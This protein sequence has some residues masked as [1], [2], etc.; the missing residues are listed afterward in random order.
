M[1]YNSLY[2]LYVSETSLWYAL[3]F[4]FQFK[5]FTNGTEGCLMHINFLDNVMHW[6]VWDSR[7]HCPF[8]HNDIKPKQAVYYLKMWWLSV[9]YISPVKILRTKWSI[10]INFI[11]T[12]ISQYSYRAYLNFLK[13]TIHAANTAM[14]ILYL[15]E[16]VW[17]HVRMNVCTWKPHGVKGATPW[18]YK[19]QQSIKYKLYFFWTFMTFL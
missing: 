12:S 10:A 18:H 6:F 17:V 2:V 19:S 16:V 15:W 14:V 9:R 7:Y 3:F 11:S 4:W 1:M 13:N 8:S 5:V